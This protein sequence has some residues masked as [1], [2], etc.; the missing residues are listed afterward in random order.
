MSARVD[1]ESRESALLFY[2]CFMWN[3]E[4]IKTLQSLYLPACL[5]LV[6][7]SSSASSWCR[8]SEDTQHREIQ[9][10]CFKT[11]SGIMANRCQ[12]I[13]S[14]C[15]DSQIKDSKL[16]YSHCCMKWYKKRNVAIVDRNDCNW[17]ECALGDNRQTLGE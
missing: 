3:W 11:S 4:R 12:D 9:K 7:L 13:C 15:T 16:H 1:S 2:I 5:R 17:I 8:L 6:I 14:G 10:M